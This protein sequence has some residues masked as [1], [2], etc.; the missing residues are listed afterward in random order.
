VLEDFGAPGF[1]G[2]GRG[3]GE[4]GHA[5]ARLVAGVVSA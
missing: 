3:G 2:D 1:D 5:E 4:G